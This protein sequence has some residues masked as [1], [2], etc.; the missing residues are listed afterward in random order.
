[1][2]ED[3][4]FSED[5]QFLS[6]DDSESILNID[7]FLMAPLNLILRKQQLIPSLSEI[8]GNSTELQTIAE[9]LHDLFN[10][11]GN[12][13][14]P[15]DS[16]QTIQQVFCTFVSIKIKEL[17]EEFKE[18][19]KEELKEEFKKE[20]TPESNS[21]IQKVPNDSKEFEDN[22]NP[23]E[24]SSSNKDQ[25]NTNLINQPPS[26]F[27][28]TIQTLEDQ[29]QQNHTMFSKLSLSKKEIEAKYEEVKKEN[30]EIEEKCQ[31]LQDSLQSAEFSRTRLENQL[32]ELRDEAEASKSAV[33]ALHSKLESRRSRSKATAKEIRSL[34]LQCQKLQTKNDQLEIALRKSQSLSTIDSNL[35]SNQAKNLN[36]SS[37][38][39]E[40]IK[41]QKA[42]T[43]TADLLEFQSNDMI[44]LREKYSG[45]LK[46]INVLYNLLLQYD[47]QTTNALENIGSLQQ[48]IESLRS[49]YEQKQNEYEENQV[50]LQRLRIVANSAISTN[51]EIRSLF[52]ELDDQEDEVLV[53]KVNTGIAEARN[54]QNIKVFFDTQED[55]KGKVV[56]VKIT[57]VLP[58]SMSGILQK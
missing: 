48:E 4:S 26:D 57:K 24:D 49:D 43:H 9:K 27:E 29:I 6:N 17:K 38:Q 36:Q 18:E 44:E 34:K 5:L 53:E 32:K 8:A 19:F 25:D 28:R 2:E 31:S 14:F 58:N 50:E 37:N 15:H 23:H 7:P 10:Q 51:N 52:S 11:P 46:L 40:L 42:I 20:N 56:N 39:A 55:L 30:E 12:I 22:F 3:F 47:S 33:I 13:K 54:S 35:N 1:M 45:G 21:N 16:R 41:L